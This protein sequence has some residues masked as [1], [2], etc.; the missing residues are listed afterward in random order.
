MA[1]VKKG[2]DREK[3]R[4]LKSYGDRTMLQR[5]MAGGGWGGSCLDFLLGNSTKIQ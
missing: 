2:L 1:Y 4:R 5:G 3:A